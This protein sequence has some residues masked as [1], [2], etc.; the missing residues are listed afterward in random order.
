ML[1]RG[2]SVGNA[3][4]ASGYASESAFSAMFK[5]TMGQPPSQFHDTR[6]R[7]KNLAWFAL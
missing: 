2:E 6:V 5:A 1:A 3:A 4:T 7:R